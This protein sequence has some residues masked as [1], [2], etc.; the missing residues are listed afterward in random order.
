MI[1]SFGFCDVSTT[2]L[3]N[4]LLLIAITH[5]YKQNTRVGGRWKEEQICDMACN[6]SY[7]TYVS[8]FRV[9]MTSFIICFVSDSVSFSLFSFYNDGK[10]WFCFFDKTF[11]NSKMIFCH[12]S[13]IKLERMNVSASNSLWKL[14]IFCHKRFLFVSVR[15]LTDKQKAK[16]FTYR[17]RLH[18]L[19]SKSLKQFSAIDLIFNSAFSIIF[20]SIV[21]VLSFMTSSAK[22]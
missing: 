6:G 17:I 12:S 4:V 21:F 10:N 1:V 20:I 8:S 22:T 16:L 18:I 3:Q 19:S 9:Y 2:E 15:K 5:K 14:E 11:M 13:V 7:R